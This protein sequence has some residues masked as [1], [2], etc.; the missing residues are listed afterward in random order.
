AMTIGQ[1]YEQIA[2]SFD[3]IRDDAKNMVDQLEDGRISFTERLSNLWTRF[4]RGDIADRFEDIRKT[5]LDVAKDTRVQ[6]ERDHTLLEADRDFRGALMQ[7]EVLRVEVLKT[8]ERV[9]DD[10][11]RDLADNSAAASQEVDDPA[12]RSRHELVRDEALRNVQNE[13]K[14]YQI[15]K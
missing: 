3:S 4:R 5:Y 8:A 1:R 11:K 7:S 13:E 9:L 10:A 14:R 12:E 2:S 6:I 15:A